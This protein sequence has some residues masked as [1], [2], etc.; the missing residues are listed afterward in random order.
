MKTINK[1]YIYLITNDVNDK[2]YVGQTTKPIQER[3]IEHCSSPSKLGKAIQSIG[4]EHFQVQL[5]DDK[6]IN[7]DEL[8]EKE[9][10]YIEKYNSL[11]NGYNSRPACKS[12][13]TIANSTNKSRITTTLD[14]ELLKQA[15][16]EAIQ[17]DI[18]VA[19]FLEKLIK[20]YFEE[21]DKE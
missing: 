5:L 15:K 1:F 11:K 20:E 13:G 9:T 21:K 19:E 2:V 10:F 12:N 16:I 7:L 3:F 6:S 4:K 14:T 8:T 18:S 17:L